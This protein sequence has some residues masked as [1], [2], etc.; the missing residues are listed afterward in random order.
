MYGGGL[1]VIDTTADMVA[2]TFAVAESHGNVV[3]SSRDSRDL[4]SVNIFSAAEPLAC[5]AIRIHY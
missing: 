1:T 4:G 3:G 2:A 5:A